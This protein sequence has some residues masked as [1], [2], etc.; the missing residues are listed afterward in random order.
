MNIALL[1]SPI[2]AYV[3]ALILMLLVQRPLFI[4]YNRCS[5]SHISL[6]DLRQV[7]GHGI[8]SDFI[9]AAYMTAVPLLYLWVSYNI[10][11]GLPLWPLGIIM[12]AISLC[13]AAIVVSD[14]A[15][16]NFWHFKID[17]SALQ[18]LR[19]PK[20]AFASVSAIY[21]LLAMT[22]ILV[23][24]TA[25]TAA[26]MVPLMAI[27]SHAGVTDLWGYT[28][29]NL[30]FVIMT[31]TL[32]VIIRGLRIRPNN[33]T[34][35]YHS[36]ISFFNHAALNAVFSFVYSLGRDD[37]YSG[38]FHFTD[39]TAG[40]ER[41][42]T[43][44]YPPTPGARLKFLNNNRPG[45]L[46]IIWESLSARF[47]EWTGGTPG[48]TPC[49][50]ALAAESVIFSN[51]R[52]GSFLT[53]RGIACLLS[54]LPGQPTAS[55]VQHTKK[56]PALPALPRKLREE[57]YTTTVVHGGDLSVRQKADY[58]LAAGNQ[59]LIAGKDLDV[60]SPRCK[61]GVHDKVVADRV[62]DEINRA[63]Q[64]GKPWM[65]TW[66]TLSSHEP[67][68]VPDNVLPHKMENAFHYTDAAVSSLIERLKASGAWDDMIVVISGDHGVYYGSEY[69]TPLSRI[70]YT[71]IPMLISGGAVNTPLDI[72]RLVSQSDLAAT[73]LG[74]ME[75][76]HDEFIY[77][78]DVLSPSYT[79]PFT[80][81]SFHHGV[82]VS[83]ERG[84]T[85]IDT[86]T[87]RVIEGTPDEHREH[88]ARAV[89]QHLYSYL[90]KL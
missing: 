27:A 7:Y 67:F 34:I 89:L 57:G 24:A 38:V 22:A 52:C 37:P 41:E 14:T 80:F 55:I 4:I 48:V 29:G 81:H 68:D 35:V 11:G 72:S 8:L 78:R 9:V 43:H 39:D 28:A 42:V 25:C 56:L 40:V 19:S 47:V 83:D 66:Q 90:A 31:G 86:D 23:V 46:F 50:N 59:R 26:V 53:D 65:I 79:T 71:H 45:V 54:G 2:A 58:Y 85:A 10:P 77:S 75:L 84:D 17:S 61:W 5:V 20:G 3:G 87:G 1:L 49:L 15:L 32:A 13:Y 76:N 82:V 60:T 69:G 33:P 70:P 30:C 21:L 62:Y 12:G 44:L 63:R 36:S 6:R 18:F 74:Q 16:Y 64:S 51:A 88:S 73:L